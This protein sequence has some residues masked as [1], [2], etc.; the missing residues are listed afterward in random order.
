MFLQ[1]GLYPPV[2]SLG[3]ELCGE[4][5]SGGFV[6]G[7]TTATPATLPDPFFNFIIMDL[8][9]R[10]RQTKQ[11]QVTMIFLVSQLQLATDTYRM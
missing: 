4:K 2:F 7:A 9:D 11:I 6:F 1:A 5:G 8:T 3:Q 10:Q